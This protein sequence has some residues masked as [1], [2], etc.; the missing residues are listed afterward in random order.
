M[1]VSAGKPRVDEMM[2]AIEMLQSVGGKVVG[3]VLNNFDVQQA[4]GIS[5][6]RARTGGY[7]YAQNF[8]NE[9]DSGL[10]QGDGQ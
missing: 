7:E 8:V 6:R 9:R 1:V 2:Q 10:R 5:P 3:V 4:Y